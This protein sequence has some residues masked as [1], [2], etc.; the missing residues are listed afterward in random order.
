MKSD[1]SGIDRAERKM[2]AWA[3]NGVHAAAEALKE[4]I[5]NGWSPVSPSSEGQPPAILTG[6][7]DSSIFVE[8]QGRDILGRFAGRDAQVWFVRIDTE[9]GENP[10]GRGQYAEVL[11]DEEQ[12]NRPFVDRAMDR[13]AQNFPIFFRKL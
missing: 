5:R 2:A 9:R 11:D 10:L 7:L 3:D 13:T 1:L 6:N 12:M 8:R 4:E